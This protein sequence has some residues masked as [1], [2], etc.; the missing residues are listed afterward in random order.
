[1]DFRELEY[2]SVIAQERNISKAAERLFV[3]QPA[4]SRALLKIEEELGIALFYRRNRQYIPTHAG[5]LYLKMAREILAIKK[6]FN[7]HIRKM[8]ES[9]SGIL[10][11][12]ITPGRARTIIPRIL[13]YFHKVF[14][15]YEIQVFEEDVVT[16]EKYLNDN[17]IEIAFF[18]M[19]EK[20]QTANNRIIY[21]LIA[22]EEVVLCT[23]KIS[24]YSFYA[25]SRED[26]VY[27]WM[28]LKL[29]ENET[30]ILLKENLRLGQFADDILRANALTP[31]IMRLSSID[32]ALA[33]VAQQYGIAFAS[34]F[35][36][37]EHESAKDIHIF[38]FGEGIID[39]D[40]VV[41]YQKDYIV[42]KPAQYII[43]LIKGLFR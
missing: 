27:P 33:L 31:Q 4:L 26:R 18:T 36:I 10:K 16:L 30:F 1:M 9:K 40:F 29:L 21:D 25:E 17:V 38:S 37:E 11:F 24:S 2:V 39:W 8:R 22:R 34:S 19:T 20:I 28:D 7:L 41:A 6:D 3:S 14:P 15:N 43:E 13:P 42:E 12:G 5:E 23:A 32:T 35:R